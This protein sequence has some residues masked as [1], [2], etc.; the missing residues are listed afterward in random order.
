M[1]FDLAWIRSFIALARTRNFSK[2]AAQNNVTQP[3]FSRR[4]RAL[5]AWLGS[6][7]I[8]RSTYPTRLTPAGERFLGVADDID[9]K[10]AEVRAEIAEASPA[11]RERVVIAAQHTLACGFLP[12]HLGDLRQDPD[13]PLCVVHAENIHDCSERLIAGNADILLAF[14]PANGPPRLAASDVECRRVGRDRLVPVVAPD[15][16]GGPRHTLGAGRREPVPWLSFGEGTLLEPLVYEIIDARALAVDPV[17]R[18]PITEVLRRFAVAGHGVGWL[19]QSIVADDLAAGVLVPA[20]DANWT[21]EL[22]VCAYRL[23]RQP[24]PA[25]ETVWSNLPEDAGP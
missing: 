9:R 14:A 10:L 6:D 2:A 18:N 24:A 23:A 16:A 12:A 8:D 19:P 7:L 3:A 11:E 1:S 25:V 4:I 20:G 5:E 15:P 22:P 13:S 17:V 21:I